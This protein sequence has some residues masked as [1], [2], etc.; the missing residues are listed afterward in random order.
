MRYSLLSSVHLGLIMGIYLVVQAE[1]SW[2]EAI[3]TSL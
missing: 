2:W 1:V 3:V